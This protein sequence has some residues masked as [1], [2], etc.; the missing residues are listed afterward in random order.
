MFCHSAHAGREVAIERTCWSRRY[1][2][3]KSSNF[4]QES[5]ACFALVE[6]GIFHFSQRNV[7]VFLTD[8]S[9]HLLSHVPLSRN[10]SA[11]INLWRVGHPRRKP[12]YLLYYW[13]FAGALERGNGGRFL[14]SELPR[15]LVAPGGSHQ[16]KGTMMWFK[17]ACWIAL[18]LAPR[19]T[20]TETRHGLHNVRS[21]QGSVFKSNIAKCNFWS[22][23]NGPSSG[24]MAHG[25]QALDRRWASLKKYTPKELASKNSSNRDLNQK[26]RDYIYSFVWRC[27]VAKDAR[28]KELGTL[29]KTCKWKIQKLRFFQCMGTKNECFDHCK[30]MKTTTKSCKYQ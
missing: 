16:Q 6:I 19:Y 23:P 24:I 2:G 7:K 11:P 20:Q 28:L 1:I 5:E 22:A 8:S 15:V 4:T 27:N 13:R 17:V 14:I 12:K 26:I 21:C 10:F 25:T 30:F 18:A 9:S 29:A 3:S